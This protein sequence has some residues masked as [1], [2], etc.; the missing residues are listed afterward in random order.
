VE[1]VRQRRHRAYLCTHQCIQYW[2]ESKAPR[3]WIWAQIQHLRTTSSSKQWGKPN[4]TDVKLNPRTPPGRSNRKARAFSAEIARLAAE[5]YGC[6]AIHQALADAG[7]SVSKSTVQREVAR[8]SRPI[9]S[10]NRYVVAPIAAAWP[11]PEA[12]KVPIPDRPQAAERP[13]SS[14]D[15]AEAFIKSRI[16]NP[17]MRKRI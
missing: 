16:T 8:L 14:K 5:G 1:R 12:L 10:I 13:P 11:E 7:V 2:L 9:P 15:I 3:R 6:T 17:L 4:Q